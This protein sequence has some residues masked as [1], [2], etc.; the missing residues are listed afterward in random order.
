M[1]GGMRGNYRALAWTLLLGGGQAQVPPPSAA[2]V[3]PP[4]AIA[5]AM[6]IA[7]AA[8]AIQAIHLAALPDTTTTLSSSTRSLSQQVHLLVGRSMF[9]KSTTRLKRI[10]VS[11]PLAVDSLT[12]SPT[13][14]VVTAKAPGLAVLSCGTKGASRRRT[15]FSRIWM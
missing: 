8:P 14:I 1:N 13:Q 2:G 4:P 3:A 10:Y 11:N 12:S 5:P 15:W 6:A 9:I 7:P